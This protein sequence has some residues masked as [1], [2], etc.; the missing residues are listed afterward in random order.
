M[1]FKNFVWPHNPR[2]YAIAFERK[3]AVHK[4]PFGLH[5]L[6]SLGQ[7][8]RV[9]RGE[10]EFVGERAYDTLKELATVF[11]EE[12]PGVLVHPVWMTTTAWFAALEL[13]QE[14]KRDYVAYSFE[15]WETEEGAGETRLALRALPGGEG[16]GTQAGEELWH[17]VAQGET[18]WGLARRY[19]VELERVIA[20]NPDIRNPNLIFPGQRVRIR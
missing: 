1:R 2:V 16:A 20:L 5:H 7:T 8:R 17:T 19:G 12:T 10:G 11:Y 6:Q 9:L 18:L 14:P 3:M 13:R 4:I 15:F